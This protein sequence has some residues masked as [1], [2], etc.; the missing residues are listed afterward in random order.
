[1][2]ANFEAEQAVLGSVLMNNAAYHEVS[3]L[4]RAEHFADPLHGK[5][6]EAMGKLIDRGQVVN[7]I[8]LKTYVETMPELREAG[9][10]RTSP[11]WL[12]PLCMR[13]T[14]PA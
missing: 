11:R 3:G 4:L 6:Y 2:P 1:M 7:S 12:V 10:P 5:L 14:P 8:V 13:S 9:G